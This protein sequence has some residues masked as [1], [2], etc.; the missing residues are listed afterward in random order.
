MPAWA[1]SPNGDFQPELARRRRRGWLKLV[2]HSVDVAAVGAELLRLPTIREPLSELA[3]RP[4][5]EIDIDRLCFF[6][7]LHDAGKVTQDFQAKLCS[8]GQKPDADHIR[9]LWSIVGTRNHVK[10]CDRTLCS[11]LCTSLA[12]ARWRSWFA[13]WETERALWLAI[14]NHHNYTPDNL[15]LLPVEPRLWAQR[16]IYD[17]LVALEKLAAAMINMFPS[18]FAPSHSEQL[19]TGCAQDFWQGFAR[20]V[21]QS[22][23]LG[24]DADVFGFP[25][26]AKSGV[27]R[28]PCSR[29]QAANK[30]ATST[31]A[32]CIDNLLVAIRPQLVEMATRKR[33]A[34]GEGVGMSETGLFAGGGEIGLWR[35]IS[36]VY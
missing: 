18:A 35:E 26:D 27:A 5:S 20:L 7:G 17:P 25:P 14:L 21:M 29:E 31:T 15:K 30:M 28:V 3:K 6:I 2:D 32:Q 13:D 8:R 19:P 16:D 23:S 4:L 36:G 10:E 1:K 11:K 24:S 34:T 9:P 12:S 22:D 33:R